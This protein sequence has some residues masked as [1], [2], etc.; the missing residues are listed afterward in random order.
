M[1]IGAFGL[2]HGAGHRGE[3]LEQLNHQRV[4]LAIPS[5]S[6]RVGSEWFDRHLV[7]LESEV[8]WKWGSSSRPGGREDFVISTTGC[9]RAAGT[10]P[11]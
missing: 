11:P 7:L 10:S 3:R 6:V 4:E 2:R 8:M 1:R 9:G 5:A